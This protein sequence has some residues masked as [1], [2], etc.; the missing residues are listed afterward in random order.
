VNGISS[1]VNSVTRKPKRN[2]TE[3]EAKGKM[4]SNRSTVVIEKPGRRSEREMRKYLINGQRGG[5]RKL[6]IY[7]NQYRDN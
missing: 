3:G 4:K 6:I 5:F 2:G 1:T 7:G